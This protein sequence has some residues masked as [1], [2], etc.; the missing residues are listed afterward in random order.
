MSSPIETGSLVSS[1]LPRGFERAEAGTPPHRY[2]RTAI[3][4]HWIVALAVMGMIGLGLWMINLPKGVGPF[5]AEMYNLHKSIGMTVGLLIF[6]R[7]AWHLAH[8]APPLPATMPRWQ[9]LASHFTHYALYACIV[10]QPVTGFVGSLCSPY[11]IKYFGH[12]L[13]FGSW[14]VPAAKEFLSIVHLANA[15]VLSVLILVHV[16]RAGLSGLCN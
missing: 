4:L 5:R 10:I 16:R 3:V 15:S 12:T 13:P 1:S 14:D 7:I 2:T 6:A 9:V 11:P 8:S